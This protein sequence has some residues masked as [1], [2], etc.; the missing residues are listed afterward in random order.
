MKP[1]AYYSL[2]KNNRMLYLSGVPISYLKKSMSPKQFSFAITSM[3]GNGDSVV[4]IDPNQQKNYFLDLLGSIEHI[5]SDVLYAIGSFP[6]DQA[7]YQM[8]AM[9]SKDFYEYQVS[10]APPKVKWID[11][12]RPDW[13]FLNS[14]EDCQLLVIH[15]LSHTSDKKRLERAKDFLHRCENATRIILANV[16]N[17]LHFAVHDMGVS[18]AAVWQLT[19]VTHKNIV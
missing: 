7:A 2:S 8:A 10:E 12:G 13:E 15:G 1:K 9:I 5:G 3:R 11:L 16:Q 4:T 19:K 18:P 17:V 14:D 6:T